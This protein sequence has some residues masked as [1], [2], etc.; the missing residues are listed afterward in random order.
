MERPYVLVIG[1]LNYDIIF[2]QERLPLR[3]ETYTG[4]SVDFCGGGKGGNQ[5]VQCA[6]L[7]LPAVM[8][9][10]V[11][12]D[13][14]GDFLL[15]QLKEY[16]VNTDHVRRSREKTGLA[17]VNALGDG[18]VHATITIGANGDFSREEIDRLEPL[19]RQSRMVVLQ[20]E[21][22]VPVVEYTVRRAKEW[23]AAVLL[24]AAPAKPVSEETLRLADYLVV[25]ETEAGFY[26][27]RTVC[28][29]EDAWKYGPL[30]QARTGQVLILTVG[31]EGALLFGKEGGMEFP[32]VNTDEVVETTG[33]GDSF[34]GG[35]VYGKYQ[36]M[37]DEE[38]CRLAGRASAVT[39]RGIGAQ[40]SMPWRKDLTEDR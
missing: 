29:K 22:P 20:L 27:E 18:S 31:A 30:L 37:T 16:G 28:G 36:G 34:I 15:E 8:I 12:E 26:L 3:G 24:N 6:K 40:A 38:A 21:I 33:A 1:S 35:F 13:Q 10:R 32:P 11:G 5:A 2:K 9:G 39:I 7:G 19:V 17:C 14:F 25:N 23:G 4:E